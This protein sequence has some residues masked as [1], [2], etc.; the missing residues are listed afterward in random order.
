MI[1]SASPGLKVPTIHQ[2]QLRASRNLGLQSVTAGLTAIMLAGC[3]LVAGVF[4][5]GIWTGVLLVVALLV[6]IIWAVSKTLTRK[7]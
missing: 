3:D 5:A 4:E 2:Q 1:R 7:S 6:L